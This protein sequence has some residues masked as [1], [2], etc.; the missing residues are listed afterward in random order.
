MSARGWGN[1]KVGGVRKEGIQSSLILCILGTL[2]NLCIC[3]C[4]RRVKLCRNVT[5][6]LVDEVCQQLLSFTAFA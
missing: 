2:C 5:E 6:F 4:V 3:A 1:S